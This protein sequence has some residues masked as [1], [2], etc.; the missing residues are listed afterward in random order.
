MKIKGK[1]RY[2][3]RA[4]DSTGQTVGFLLTARRD[5]EFTKRFFRKAFCGR[6]IQWHVLSVDKNPAYPAS[7]REL[8]AEG[9]LPAVSG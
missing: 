8:K 5:K 6:A 3:Y 2:L 4:V 9:T 7:V 1:D